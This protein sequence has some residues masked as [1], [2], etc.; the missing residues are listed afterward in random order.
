MLGAAVA[1]GLRLRSRSNRGNDPAADQTRDFDASEPDAACRAGNEHGFARLQARAVNEGVPGGE[2]GVENGRA[3][4]EIHVVWN[5]RAFR[6][7]GDHALGKAAEPVSAGDAVARAKAPDLVADR[8]HDPSGV[9]SRHVRERRPHLIAA[10]GH[11]IIHV[12]DRGCVNVD[13]DLVGGGNRLHG[14]AHAQRANSL[15]PITK[16]RAHWGSKTTVGGTLPNP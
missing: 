8:N 4:K 11:Q 12:A 2:V 16:N 9:R 15:E 5:S 14:L 3:D 6:G 7:F 1:H 10:G 13:Q